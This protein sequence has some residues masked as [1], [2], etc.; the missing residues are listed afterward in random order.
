MIQDDM[1]IALVVVVVDDVFGVG[2]S[3]RYLWRK[4]QLR[5]CTVYSSLPS[6]PHN[7]P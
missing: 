2:H 3:D 5:T 4:R 6:L 7:S 1:M